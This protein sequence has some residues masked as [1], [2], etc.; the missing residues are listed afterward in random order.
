MK[1]TLLPLLASIL[2]LASCAEE[3]ASSSNE[4]SSEEAATSSSEETSSS[5]SS[6]SEENENYKLLRQLENK[7]LSLEG[8]VNKTN[9]TMNRVVTQ[10]S[11]ISLSVKD[12]TETKRYAHSTSKF[13]VETK[14]TTAYEGEGASG[15]TKQIYDNGK[16]F[17]Q[18]TKY[19][20]QSPQ[21]SRIKFSE[22]NVESIYDIGPAQSQITDFENIISYEQSYI[23]QDK[24]DYFEW[25]F[26]NLEGIEEDEYLKYSYTVSLYEDIEG[27]KALSQKTEYENKFTIK[28]DLIV[29]LDQKCKITLVTGGIT[30]LANTVEVNLTTTY[31][32]G[33]YEEFTGTLLSTK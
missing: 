12:V 19:D 7:L 18:I 31:S 24:A 15:Y 27:K 13:V 5:E 14:G 8:N 2:L 3:T 28:N 30:E 1:K 6:S 33:E 26:D 10:S 29:Q 16:Y 22:D 23:N 9:T 25:T 20:D 17:Y 32:Q 21:S 11:S 4:A